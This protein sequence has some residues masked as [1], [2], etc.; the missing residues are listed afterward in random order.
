MS[1]YRKD[2]VANQLEETLSGLELLAKRLR[3]ETTPDGLLLDIEQVKSILVERINK[4][5]S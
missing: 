3:F 2:Q 4:L 1:R 5:R